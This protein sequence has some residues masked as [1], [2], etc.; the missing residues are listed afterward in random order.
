MSYAS[1]SSDNMLTLTD[2]NGFVL[3]VNGRH[4]ITDI[5][6]NDGEWHFICVTWISREGRYEIYVDGTLKHSGKNLSPGDL[7][8]ANGTIIIGQEQDSVGTS[9]SES[10]SFVG[11]VAYFDIWD[12]QISSSEMFDYYTTCEPYQGSLYAWTDFKINIKGNV[13]VK[14]SPFC[15]QCPKNLH[16]FNGHI[17]YLSNRAFHYCHEGYRINGPNVRDCLRTS[18]W[19]LPVPSC[20]SKIA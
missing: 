17:R 1:E 9:F 19:S 16:L 12:R 2:Y 20:R 4:I 14:T 13:R 6:L 7:I 5:I 18:Q 10:E 3:Y 11:R 8:E 15:R